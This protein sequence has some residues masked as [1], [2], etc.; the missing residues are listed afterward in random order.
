MPST[1]SNTHRAY[2]TEV[3]EHLRRIVT[4]RQ[5]SAEQMDA[6]W[7]QAQIGAASTD[8]TATVLDYELAKSAY[9]EAKAAADAAGER[10][11]RAAQTL[12]DRAGSWRR[13]AELADIH[14][15]TLR[16]H[17]GCGVKGRGKPRR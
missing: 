15:A 7:E 8:A 3:G 13:A 10:L 12:R 16:R 17:A 11:E 9:E 5:L 6:A 14:E 1:T 2:A 4:G